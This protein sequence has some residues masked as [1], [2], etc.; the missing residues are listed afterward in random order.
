M[1]P[2]QPFVLEMDA[3]GH[4]IGVVLLQGIRPIVF[5]SKKLDNA[6][7]NYLAYEPELYAIVHALR[8]W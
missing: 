5:E 2:T 3:S 1:D 7:C 4:A 8:K 6:Q